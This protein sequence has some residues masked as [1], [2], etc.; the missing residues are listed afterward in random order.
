MRPPT[1]QECKIIQAKA[2]EEGLTVGFGFNKDS[3]VKIY[4][5]RGL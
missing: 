1:D 4:V 5:L 3:E 2:A